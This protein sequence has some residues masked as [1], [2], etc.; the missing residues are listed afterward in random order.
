MSRHLGGWTNDGPLAA[1]DILQWNN[2]QQP[3][4]EAFGGPA[5]EHGEPKEFAGRPETFQ[6]DS[7]GSF[8]KGWLDFA[9]VGPPSDAPQPSAVVINTTDAHGHMTKALA[10]LPAVAEAQGIFRPIDPTN[11]YATH[12]DVRIDQFGDTDPTGAVQDPNNPGFLLCGCPVGT[13]NILDVPIAVGFLNA[14]ANPTNPA[15]AP[16]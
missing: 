10:T 16:G 9:A 11:H 2:Q 4:A 6:R 13:E 3:V 12:A 14:G 1:D 5:K 15:E 7:V 8:P